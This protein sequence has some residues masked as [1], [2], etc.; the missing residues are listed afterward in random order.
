M[1]KDPRASLRAALA[2]YIRATYGVTIEQYRDTWLNSPDGDTRY[3]FEALH[4]VD[5]YDSL[6]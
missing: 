6:A 2:A 5:I 4:L 1:T 3:P